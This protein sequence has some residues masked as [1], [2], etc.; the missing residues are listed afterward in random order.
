MAANDTQVGGQHYMSEYQHWDFVTSLNLGYLIGNAT[1]YVARAAKKN[2]AEDLRKALH[3]IT[4]FE[5][6]NKNRALPTER[7]AVMYISELATRIGH[8]PG[9]RANKALV[10]LVQND[11]GLAA[12]WIHEMF[13]EMP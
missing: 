9:T 5:E 10:A 2:G 1:K 6:V 13:A 12:Q 4:K 11:T 7:Y 3:Y 8:G